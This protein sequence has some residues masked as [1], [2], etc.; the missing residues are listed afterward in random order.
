MKHELT[1]FGSFPFTYFQTRLV[2]KPIR[3][4]CDHTFD[5]PHSFNRMIGEHLPR[6]NVFESRQHMIDVVNQWSPS[7][8]LVVAGF[9]YRLPME[10]I[11]KFKWVINMHPGDLSNNR[12]ASPLFHSVVRREPMA[13][14]SYHQIV[15]EELD[16]GP[17]ALVG[18]FPIHY[19][20]NYQHLEHRMDRASGQML[21]GLL[22][23]LALFGN[24][25]THNV[26]IGPDSYQKRPSA[27]DIG[28]MV[29]AET[30]NEFL[31]DM[32]KP[33]TP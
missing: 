30:L 23:E 14:V 21:H 9:Q 11:G 32:C 31:N 22:S 5:Y 7:D 6:L 33:V 26:S 25:E 10:V 24:L 1:F 17:L 29:Q 18:K 20:R 13:T 8:I 4:Y 2:S 19:E 15:N 12:G 16:C 27:D 3:A 28:K